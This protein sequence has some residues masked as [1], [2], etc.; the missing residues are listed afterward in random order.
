MVATCLIMVSKFSSVKN[1][2]GFIAAKIMIISNS[3]I[4][5]TNFF[6][7]I[8]TVVF[9][10]FSLA[11]AGCQIQQYFFIKLLTACLSRK[12]PLSKDDNAV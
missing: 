6:I 4:C 10:F 2:A 5:A 3:R 9:I 7:I 11:A 12:L 8:N 1:V